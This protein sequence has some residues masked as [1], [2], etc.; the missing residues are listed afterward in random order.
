MSRAYGIKRGWRAGLLVA[1]VMAQLGLIAPAQIYAQSNSGSLP[2]LP[3]A[4]VPDIKSE[5]KAKLTRAR[6]LLAQNCIDEAESIA[7]EV[8]QLKLHLSRLEESPAKILAD[9][10]RVRK[11]PQAM[12]LASR[13]AL[14]RKELD[15]AE[16]YAKT[17]EKNAS[18]FSFNVLGDTPSKAL[19]DIATAR[20]SESSASNESSASPLPSAP[21]ASPAGRTVR[22]SSEEKAQTLVKQARAAMAAGK[23]DEARKLANDAAALKASHGWW[24]DTPDKVLADLKRLDNG[25]KPAGP[26]DV[27]KK[28]DDRVV[29]VE[30]IESADKVSLSVDDSK[31]SDDKSLATGKSAPVAASGSTTASAPKASSSSKPGLPRT[32]AEAVQLL[33][34]GRKALDQGK[35][36]EAASIAQRCKGANSLSWGLFERD[37]P[38]SLSRDVGKARARRDREEA[39]KLLVEGRKLL[40]KGDHEGASRLAYRSQTLFNGYSTWDMSDRP[41]KLLADCQAIKIRDK[42]LPKLPGSPGTAVVKRETPGPTPL[43]GLTTPPGT[44]PLPTPNLTAMTTPPAGVP[45]EPK[46]VEGSDKKLQAQQLVAEAQRLQREGKLIDAKT[47]AAQALRLNATFKADEAA[48]DLVFQQV[49]MEARRKVESLAREAEDLRNSGIGDKT[50]RYRIAERKLVEARE[51]AAGFG[52]DTVPLDNQLAGLRA[53]NKS[54]AEPTLPP[55]TTSGVIQT[56]DLNPAPS[57]MNPAN[58]DLGGLPIASPTSLAGSM[59][60]NP[61]PGV[62]SIPMTPSTSV[63]GSMPMNPTPGSGISSSGNHGAQLL[64]NSR[65]ELKRGEIATARRI[66]EEALAGNHGVKDQAM[67]LLR[68]IDVEEFNQKR[69]AANRSFDAVESAYRRREFSQAQAMLSMIDARLLDNSRQSRLREINLTPEMNP[70]VVSKTPVPSTTRVV[71]NSPTT[72]KTSGVGSSSPQRVMGE[73]LPSVSGGNS[74]L[75]QVSD[76]RPASDGLGSGVVLASGTSMPSS[77]GVGRATASD[78]PQPSIQDEYKQRQTALFQMMR[79]KGLDAQSQAGEKFRTGQTEAALE[80]LQEYLN[81]VTDARLESSQSSLLRRPVE[82]RL[83]QYRLI[84]A[85]KDM[86]AGLNAGKN[87]AQDRVNKSRQA[88]ELKRKN[89]EDLMRQYNAKYTAKD[90]AGAMALASRAHDLDPDNPVVTAALAISRRQSNLDEYNKIKEDRSEMW[91]K[92]ANDAERENGHEAIGPGIAFDK[93]RWEEAKKR[94][95]FGPQRIGKTGSKERTIESKLLSP[96]NLNFENT[97]LKQVIDDLRDFHGINIV[98]DLPALQSQGTHLD[99]P[100]SIK[101]DQVS[102]KSALNLIL[103]QVKLTYVIKDEVLQITTEENAKG[104]LVTMTYQVADLVVPMENHAPGLVPDGSPSNNGPMIQYTPTPTTTGP[105]LYAGTA[106]GTPT[107]TTLS[108]SGSGATATKKYATNTQ[109]EQLIKL[110]TQSISPKSWSDVGG[111]GTIEFY[112]ITFGLVINQT[113]DIQEQIQDLLAALRRLQDQSVSIEVRLI[114]VSEDFFE[115]IGVN[116]AMNILTDKANRRFEPQLL[117]G[118]FVSNPQQFINAFDPKRFIAGLT[119]AG[120]LTPTLDIPITQQSFY[121]TFPTYGNY[122]GGGLNVGLAFLS[123]IQVFLMLEALQ[124]DSRANVMQAP[125]I[126]CANG[127]SASISINDFIRN[128]VVGVSVVGLPGGQFAF[129]PQVGQTPIGGSV[130][131]NVQPLITDD[132]RFVRISAPLTLTSTTPGPIPVFPLVVPLFSSLDGIQTGQPVVFT[133]YIQQPRITQLSVQTEVRIPDGGTVVLGGLK[134]MSEARTEFGPPVLSKIPYVNRLF[135]NVGYGKETE[136]LLIMITARIIVLAEEQERSTGF[137]PA[138]AIPTP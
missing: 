46:S 16:R 43:T 117:N 11:D 118:N 89:V 110:I 25:R 31:L 70:S 84:K 103:H 75:V 101:L 35:L 49:S 86:V 8:A 20:K 64:E 119:P 19:R 52:H 123:D 9:V 62:G 18:I 92:A 116:F 33:A 82:S 36:D 130:Q 76:Q 104:K 65:M 102:L 72:L 81:E 134:R 53:V 58:S 38:D 44:T 121:Q 2:N 71:N 74:G 17:A 4:T 137:V 109:E 66:A 50:I 47:K 21:G 69:L 41:N 51:L 22:G 55:L 133:Q 29:K 77:L 124:G 3:G 39:A 56:A 94:Q 90:F 24:D 115:R 99:S 100:I 28:S 6:S 131:L 122:T 98:P 97:P 40:A 128:A 108:T 45:T 91:R 138:A 60:M 80:I 83:S 59:P 14:S 48:P 120:T 79:Q 93:E 42:S 13:A 87:A 61:P 68:T 15:A 88:E 67:D 136:S 10:E 7:K 106:T 135:K 12:L 113:P 96:V 54:P 132:R 30:E 57:P 26:Q 125:K 32:K 105:S 126:T 78:L 127:Q 1:G 111:A 129:Q 34:E 73:P 114:T 37:T 85:Q 27:V 107:G 23:P 63:V 112:P 95:P 5:A